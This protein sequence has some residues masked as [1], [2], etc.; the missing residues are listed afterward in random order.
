MKKRILVI[1]LALAMGGISTTALAAEPGQFYV[2][3]GVGQAKWHVDVPG[4]LSGVKLD[5]SDTTASVRFGYVWHWSV[6]FAV[7][8]GYVDLGKL[9]SNYADQY[10]TIRTQIKNQGAFAGVKVK[11]G[12]AQNWYVEGRGGLY[13][14]KVS[15]DGSDVYVMNGQ[16][17]T[18]TFSTDE[19]KTNWYAGVGVGYDL[20]RQFSLGLNY[21]YY[22]S[23]FM[24]AD[25]NVGTVT[26]SAEY[27]F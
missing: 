19:T 13:Q 2:G 20:S 26:V 21:D 23:K 24:D 8:G 18:D 25:L 17:T 14:A 3:A 5:D 10:D 1:G 12:F 9:T 27:R 7:E 22:R 16:Q 11:Y 6:D 4:G 15:Q